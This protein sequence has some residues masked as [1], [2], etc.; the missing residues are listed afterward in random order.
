M[1]LEKVLK[2]AEEL[3]QIG[4]RNGADVEDNNVAI[5]SAA[6]I[7][8]LVEVVEAW[9]EAPMM[10]AHGHDLA[11]PLFARLRKAQKELQAL[12]DGLEV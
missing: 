2:L 10:I 11:S 6:A 3:E 7:R 1:A 12:N 8:A 4:C 5:Q 9:R